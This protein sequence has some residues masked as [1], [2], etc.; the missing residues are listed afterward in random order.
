[1]LNE[2]ANSPDLLVPPKKKKKRKQVKESPNSRKKKDK[3]EPSATNGSPV[4]Q[5]KE[6]KVEVEE[7]EPSVAKATPITLKEVKQEFS[8]VE[9]RKMKPVIALP[10]PALTPASKRKGKRPARTTVHQFKGVSETLPR[11]SSERDKV[12]PETVSVKEEV[13]MPEVTSSAPGGGYTWRTSID[14]NDNGKSQTRDDAPADPIP[15]STN[16]WCVF[17]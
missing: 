8:S 9:L 3:V 1:M 6:V 7:D 13:I 14:P 5:E 15:E 2:T 4:L 12:P 16:N 17:F 10:A 11:S